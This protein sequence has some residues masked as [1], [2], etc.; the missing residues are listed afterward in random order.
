M[1]AMRPAPRNLLG[2]PTLT[3]V[4][5]LAG[6]AAEPAPGVV[7]DLGEEPPV[8]AAPAASAAHDVDEEQLAQRVTAE[9]QRHADRMLE[10]SLREA[11][12][13]ALALAAETLLRELRTVFSATLHDVV[14]RSVRQE[15]ERQR[16]G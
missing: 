2:L 7:S 11:I 9:L 12:E 13:P 3:E 4:I 15:L 10:Q 8:A 14:A 6:P 1:T 16:R 5:D